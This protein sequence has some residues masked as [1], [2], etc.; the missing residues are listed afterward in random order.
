MPWFTKK[1]RRMQVSAFSAIF[2][3]D[4]SRFRCV[5]ACFNHF[6]ACYGR[7]GRIG[8]QPIWHNMADTARFWPNQPGSAWIEADSARIEPHSRR[9]SEKK[10]K[11]TDAVWRAGNPVGC[12]VPCR[13]ASDAGAPPLVPRP[14]FLAYQII[15]FGEREREI[16]NEEFFMNLKI[17][18]AHLESN[19]HQSTNLRYNSIKL[20]N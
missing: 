17:W 5:S 13:A 10:K 6:P 1:E 20:I 19:L 8:R 2:K 7:I 4:F 14:C 3:A 16:P 12:R 18:W 11:N 9:E 15:Y